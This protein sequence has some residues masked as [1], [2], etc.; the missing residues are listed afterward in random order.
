MAAVC[1]TGP[2]QKLSDMSRPEGRPADRF[3][4]APAEVAG[5]GSEPVVVTWSA[6][7]CGRPRRPP[8][9]DGHIEGALAAPRAAH[10]ILTVTTEG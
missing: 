1:R 10:A 2:S 3:G 7:L 8:R 4:L 6:Q 5:L 9:Q